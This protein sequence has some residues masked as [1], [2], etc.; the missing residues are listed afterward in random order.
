[1]RQFALFS[2]L[3]TIEIWVCPTWTLESRVKDASKI[4]KENKSKAQK[5]VIVLKL[6]EDSHDGQVYLTREVTG[7]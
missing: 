6:Q 4:L 3:N 7:V 5:R 1:M 2:H